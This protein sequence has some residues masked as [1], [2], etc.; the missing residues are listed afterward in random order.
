MKKL[1]AAALLAALSGGIALA[2]S[3]P[4]SPPDGMPPPPQMQQM[5][6]NLMHVHEQARAAILAALTPAH[7]AL[8]AQITGQLAVA[9]HPDCD[10]AAKQLNAALSSSEKQAI[11]SAA[12]SAMTKMHAMMPPERMGPPGMAMGGMPGEGEM[13]RMT[14][15]DILLMLARLSITPS[16]QP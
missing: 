9:N 8:F 13:A 12:Q 10:A 16:R 5:R 1:M 6:A 11:V 4:P 7:K 15:G 3:A 14:A 2:Q